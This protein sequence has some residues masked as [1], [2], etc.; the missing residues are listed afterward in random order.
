MPR[1]GSALSGLSPR[2]RGNQGHAGLEGH[3]ARS[4]PAWAGEPRSQGRRQPPAEVYP[5]VGGGTASYSEQS[6]ACPGLSPRGR[7]NLRPADHCRVC[8]R[9]IPAW[10]GEPHPAPKRGRFLPV[11]PRVGGGTFSGLAYLPASGG[12]SPRGRGNPG[13]GEPHQWYCRSIPAWAGEPVQVVVSIISS[14]VYPRV[15]GGT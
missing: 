2:G 3:L 8:T 7:G 14:P 12:L 9:S 1:S 11:Y 13:P 10:A 5:R 6:Q 15:G 4:I